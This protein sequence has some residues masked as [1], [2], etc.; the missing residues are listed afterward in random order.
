MTDYTHPKLVVHGR[1]VPEP[2]AGPFNNAQEAQDAGYDSLNPTTGVYEIGV[3]IEGQFVPLI[4]EKASLVFDRIAAGKAAAEA[5]AAK[6]PADS[7][8]S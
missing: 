3:E 2:N 4:S 6:K 1:H 5:A 8:G 7:S